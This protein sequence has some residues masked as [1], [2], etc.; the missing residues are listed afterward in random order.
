MFDGYSKTVS[1]VQDYTRRLYDND[2]GQE[3]DDTVYY[4][5]PFSPYDFCKQHHGG[6]G[7][8]CNSESES[9]YTSKVNIA[10]DMKRAGVNVAY[11]RSW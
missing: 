10:Q 9:Q 1:M 3:L 6:N 8:L 11:V 4:K 5:T 7:A 2:L